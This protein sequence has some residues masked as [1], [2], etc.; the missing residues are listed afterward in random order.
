MSALFPSKPEELFEKLYFPER[1]V[2]WSVRLWID[3][4]QSWC[5]ISEQLQDAYRLARV[6]N[7][8]WIW[9]Q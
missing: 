2:L 1:L 7:A 9:T 4:I 5:S 3:G 8:I 6:D